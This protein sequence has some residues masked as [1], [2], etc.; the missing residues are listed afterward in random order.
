MLTID[1]KCPFCGEEYEVQVPE[2]G[3][4]R[5]QAGALIQVAM[6]DVS[7]KVREALISGMCE[8]CWT[9]LF[10]GDDDE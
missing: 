10:G 2:A 5:W 9:N 1:V 8:N 6:P 4:K 7:R 3:Y